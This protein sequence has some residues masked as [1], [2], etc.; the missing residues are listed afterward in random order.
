MTTFHFVL[1]HRYVAGIQSPLPMQLF[2]NQIDLLPGFTDAQIFALEDAP[3]P[4]VDPS[5]PKA[6]FVL[7]ATRSDPT[8]DVELPPGVVW[9]QDANPLIP[10][11]PGTQPGQ[12]IPTPPGLPA[13]PG[14]TPSTTPHES[15]VLVGL[16][17]NVAGVV[18]SREL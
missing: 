7:V 10:T 3:I 4:A 12:P 2:V 17:V 8:D 13:L 5:L 6:D 16:G 14:T 18:V 9:V 1:G 15:A 11:L